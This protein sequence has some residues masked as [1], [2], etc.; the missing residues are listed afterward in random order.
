MHEVRFPNIYILSH[1]IYY[2]VPVTIIFCLAIKS[3]RFLKVRQTL[4]PYFLES[5]S[6]TP[7]NGLSNFNN[8]KLLNPVDGS[9]ENHQS[10]VKQKSKSYNNPN[11]NS[12]ISKKVMVIGDSIV[13]Y[14][15]SD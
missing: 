13:K 3:V 2:I 8:M 12:N 7:D 15:R 10:N 9:R 4:V 11:Q 6:K 14:L 1:I 5:T